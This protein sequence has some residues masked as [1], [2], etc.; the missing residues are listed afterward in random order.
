MQHARE[1]EPLSASVN[2]YLGVA[3]T[4]AGQYDL[5]SAADTAKHRTGSRLLQILHV[6]GQKPGCVERYDE[7]IAAFQK[8]L[9]LTPDNLESL[10]FLG[11]GPGRQRATAS[12]L[13]TSSK[14]LR[15]A[16]DRTEPAVLVPTIY[17]SLGI[18]DEMYEWLERAVAL[19]ST[20]IYIAVLT[21]EF[22]PYRTDPRY[23][24]FLASIGLS[25]LARS[26]VGRRD[27]LVETEEIVGIV[28]LLE[29]RESRVVGAV[30]GFDRRRSFIAK[31]VHIRIGSAEGVQS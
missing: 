27:V 31:I 24:A 21:E 20:P 29:A 23:H 16:E 17:A 26:L 1:I 4:H 11:A 6:Y 8:A 22:R 7:A 28:L 3:Q 15:A 25:H 30:R 14:R 12:A 18:A 10:A 2:L 5:A 9:S 13:S 19:K